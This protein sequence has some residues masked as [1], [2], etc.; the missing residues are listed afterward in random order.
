MVFSAADQLS[1]LHANVYLVVAF[2]ITIHNVSYSSQRIS[3]NAP[4]Q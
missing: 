3:D 2:V 4:I 1:V